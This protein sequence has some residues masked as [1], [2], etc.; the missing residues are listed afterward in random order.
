ML[1]EPIQI[2]SLTLNNRLVMAPMATMFRKE[3]GL[4][5]EETL[6]YYE[7]RAKGGLGLIETEYTYI[8]PQG[9]AYAEQIP[10]YS[11]DCIPALE[12]L[13]CTVKSTGNTKIFVQM[14][15]AGGNGDPMDGLPPVAP[16][17]MAYARRSSE[18]NAAE[19]TVDEIHAIKNDFA[20]A[21]LRAK[22]AGFD[23]VEIHGAHGY[24]LSQFLSPIT[25]KRTDLY[26]GPVENRC[27]LSCEIL[28]AVRE[29]V[30]PDYPI[31]YRFGVVDK[32]ENGLTLEDAVIAAKMFEESGADMIS[33]TGG[34]GGY[35]IPGHMDPGY[36]RKESNAIKSAI[37]I[38]VMLTGGITTLE[39]MEEL[40]SDG[41]ADLIGI[42][43]PLLKDP[44]WALNL[45]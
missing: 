13:V 24:L 44:F 37:N 23:G 12:K 35:I 33:V 34:L 25:N 26:G 32:F 10:I 5:N 27:R 42:G 11:D 14:A 16:S 38:P 1:Y 22:K 41:S 39:L 2:N 3:G 15:H 8:S 29:A 4:I 36:F 43:R 9:R 31:S 7:E 17:A 30:G 21:A 28:S 20:A 40:L 18:Q 19:L 45:K 6:S